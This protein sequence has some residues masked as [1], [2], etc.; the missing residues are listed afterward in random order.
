MLLFALLACNA[1]PAVCE[2]M[3]AAA[4]VVQADCLAQDGL[5][6]EA[7]GYADE[8]SFLGSCDTWVW[9]QLQLQRDAGYGRSELEAIC[10][11]RRATL[12]DGDC[13]ALMLMDWS[14]RIEEE[15]P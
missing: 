12:E 15:S 4:A 5:G 11:D 10:D 13:E 2:S 1:P 6:W 7:A 3:C 9:E 8:E 14:G